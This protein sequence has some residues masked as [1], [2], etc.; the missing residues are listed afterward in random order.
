MPAETTA[1]ALP[2]PLLHVLARRAAAAVDAGAADPRRT[3]RELADSVLT[4]GLAGCRGSVTVQAA[5]LSE[6]AEAC[7]ARAFS[8]PGGIA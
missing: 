7:M 8:A 4:L 6:L 1:T 3:L 2:T 5:V